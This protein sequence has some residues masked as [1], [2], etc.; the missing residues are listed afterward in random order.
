MKGVSGRYLKQIL[1]QDSPPKLASG[2]AHAEP[3][4]ALV[5]NAMLPTKLGEHA[6][7]DVNHRV[8]VSEGSKTVERVLKK[9]PGV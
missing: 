5:A 3:R 2:I 4:G 8:V 1:V 6:L 9:R 7:R